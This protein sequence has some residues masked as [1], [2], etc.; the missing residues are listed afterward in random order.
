MKKAETK[1]DISLKSKKVLVIEDFFNF[2]LT[3]KNMLRS[4]GV[5]YI[6]DATDGEEAIHKMTIRRFDVVLCDYNLGQGKSGQQVLEEARYRNYINYST[7]FIMVTAEN[8]LEMIMGAAEHQPDDY[9]MKPFAK[10]VLEKKIRS[11]IQKKENFKEIDKAIAENSYA[12]AINLCDDLIAKSPRNLSELLKLKGELLLKIGNYQE[13][14]D[15]Y[16]KVLLMGNVG[17]AELG[18]GKA[19]LM[20][21]NYLQAK[22]IFEGILAKNDKIMA[23][24][25]YLAQTLAKL[26]KHKE[27]QQ[28]LMKATNISPRAIM[29]QKAL[30]NLAYRNDD[31]SVA[32]N[33]FKKAVEHGKYSCMRSPSDYTSLAKTLVHL[34][35]SEESLD[36]LNVALKEFPDSDEAKLHVSVT[37]SYV[38]KKMNREEDARKAMAE[39]NTIAESI[40]GGIPPEVELELAKTYIMMG[41]EEKGTKIIKR[42]VQCN[43]DREETIDIVKTVFKEVGR[44]DNGQQ[45]IDRAKD[46]IIALN[47]EGV[48]LTQEG[49]IEEAIDYFE[50][51]ALH[52]PENKIINANAAQVLMLYMKEYGVNE[53]KIA[54]TKMYLDMVKKIDDHYKD[55]P[56]LQAMY[57]ELVPG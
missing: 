42:I 37:E 45:F 51:A 7:V 47:N 55:L 21:G 32:E 54:K 49:R 46:E 43:Y 10:E 19:D 27:A 29:R 24:Y 2:R 34:D 4:F 35:A 5:L 8:T 9:L 50:K 17:W 30:G 14:Y 31:F 48:A 56:M 12:L 13:A 40:A 25:D 1:N 28:V 15:F 53:E 18:R 44:E 52:V 22:V 41:E 36:V 20:L 3:M 39:A 33:S 26:E 57:N 23:A 38:Y 11:L 16:E 6:D